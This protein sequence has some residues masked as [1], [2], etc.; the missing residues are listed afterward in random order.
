MIDFIEHDLN[1]GRNPFN[2]TERLHV[3]STPREQHIYN[4]FD[5]FKEKGY[6]T[7]PRGYT[8]ATFKFQ[9]RQGN[10]LV[11]SSDKTSHFVSTG[12]EYLQKFRG[13]LQESGESTLNPEWQRAYALR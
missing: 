13:A 1:T 11:M 4:V 7:N 8:L 3:I 5:T 2:K 9:D 6:V 12:Y 10:A